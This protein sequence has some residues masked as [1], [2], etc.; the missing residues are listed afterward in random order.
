QRPRVEAVLLEARQHHRR[1]GR[2]R[3]PERQQRH[4][5]AG[6]RRIVGG[7]RPRDTLDRALAELLR[8][9]GQPPLGGIGQEGRDLGAAGRQRA[10]R[11]AEQRAAQPRHPRPP[12]ILARH[13]QRAAH[14]L[15][16]LLGMMAARGDIERLPHRE[17]ADRKRRHLDAVEQFR[18]AEGKPRLPGELVD[19]DK[20]ERQSNEQAG[21]PADRRVAEGRRHRDEGDAHQRE[22]ILGP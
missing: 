11:K 12:P 16:L 10:D 20:A 4:Q 21:Q 2:G 22:I 7:L 19:A 3:Q 9:F 13:P 8:M 15:E 1:G 6:G 14:R 17:Q 5:R 18:D